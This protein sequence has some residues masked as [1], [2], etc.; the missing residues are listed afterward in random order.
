MHGGTLVAFF[1]TIE[2][3]VALRNAG[4][5]QI[6]TSMGTTPK[7]QIRTGALPANYARLTPLRSSQNLPRRPVGRA[8]PPVSQC[9]ATGES[10][11]GVARKFCYFDDP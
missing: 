11:G 2:M 7:M 9:S 8:R 1:M 5:T 10:V 3:S 4:S 6:E